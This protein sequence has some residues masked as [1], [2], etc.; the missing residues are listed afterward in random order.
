MQ[1]GKAS[2]SADRALLQR[3]QLL[4]TAAGKTHQR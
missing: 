2:A 3:H 1:D 4:D